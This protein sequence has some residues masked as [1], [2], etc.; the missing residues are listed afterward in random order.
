MCIS[1]VKVKIEKISKWVGI[2]RL[3]SWLYI[4]RLSG[5]QIT[6]QGCSLLASEL[7]SCHSYLKEL[8]LSY[9]HLGES[10]I[11]E[12]TDIQNDPSCKLET[13]RWVLG[14][15]LGVH[16]VLN[17]CWGHQGGGGQEDFHLLFT[18]APNLNCWRCIFLFLYECACCS[19]S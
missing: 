14:F 11:R 7:K 2:N 4:F 3:P 16:N 17:R 6:N 8:D 9:N 19:F 15:Y 1:I 13:F 12:L 5:C 10:G 18:R